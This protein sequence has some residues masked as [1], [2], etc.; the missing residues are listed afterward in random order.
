MPRKLLWIEK[1]KFAG[2]GCSECAWAFNPS[3]TPTGKSLDEVMQTY[4]QQRDA[5]FAS[6]LCAD[7]PRVPKNP[8]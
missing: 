7:H 1:E 8:H 2:W 6:H 3:G 5:D 4:K